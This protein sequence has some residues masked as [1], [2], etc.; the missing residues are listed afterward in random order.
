MLADEFAARARRLRWL[1]FDV[2]GTLTDGRLYYSAE[3]F[4]MKAFDVRD[5]L[6][7]KLAQKAGLGV[8]TLSGR[9]DA[10]LD[11]RASELGFDRVLDGIRDKAAAFESFLAEQ[12][13]EPAQVA[14]IGDDLPELPILTRVGL[15]FAPADA[16]PA[17]RERVHVVLAARGGRGAAREMVERI[18]RAR[19]EWEGLVAE[20][21]GPGG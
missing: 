13:L 18:L 9:D 2:D 19:G 4:A 12:G 7:I 8:A 14:S 20:L 3:G 21:F 10:A 5:G 6:G 11:R 16:D 1:L 15:S 17:I